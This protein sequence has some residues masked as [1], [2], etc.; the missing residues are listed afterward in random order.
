MEASLELRSVNMH[1]AQISI[2]SGL[3]ATDLKTRLFASIDDVEKLDLTIPAKQ[4]WIKTVVT[5]GPF[6]LE[7]LVE[8][9]AIFPQNGKTDT[10]V[11]I[12]IASILNLQSR[13]SEAFPTEGKF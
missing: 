13:G 7:G 10:P 8:I 11:M 3:N 5:E 2:G 12:C 6:T 4:L 1:R 9:K